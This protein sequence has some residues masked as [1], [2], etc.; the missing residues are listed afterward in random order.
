[1]AWN[2]HAVEQ[3]QLR[4]HFASMA[5][6]ARNLMSTQVTVLG[7]DTVYHDD[8]MCK[9]TYLCAKDAIFDQ[10]FSWM[11]RRDENG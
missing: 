10:H 6:G 4:R 5:W 8:L 2:R 9:H 3:T 11:T 7:R 1:M